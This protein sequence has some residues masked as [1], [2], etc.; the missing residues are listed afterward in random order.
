MLDGF[1]A[2][3]ADRTALLSYWT[4]PDYVDTRVYFLLILFNSS[5]ESLDSPEPG[6][7]GAQHERVDLPGLLARLA[8]RDGP[9]AVRAV[10][11]ELG[12][13]VDHHQLPGADLDVAG[14]RV[15]SRSVGAG[16]DDRLEARPR[17][18][19]VAH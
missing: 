1:R 12:A 19:R 10:P 15:R 5:S 18:A 2:P 14:L 16:G 3:T 11:V 8:A 6:Q 7:L 4:S 9:G 13:P 17:R